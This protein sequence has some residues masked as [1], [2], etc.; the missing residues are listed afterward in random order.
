MWQGLLP[1]D[2]TAVGFFPLV[3]MQNTGYSHY[4][5]QLQSGRLESCAAIFR[6]FALSLCDT[7]ALW[8]CA[9]S[10]INVLACRRRLPSRVSLLVK[11][12]SGRYLSS[13]PAFRLNAKP[14]WAKGEGP[15]RC[16]LCPYLSLSTKRIRNTFFA[17]TCGDNG[18]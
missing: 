5:L 16:M 18:Q 2:N 12:V 14:T 1:W 7:Y 13:Q 15:H 9:L 4:G 3:T 17:L 11:A 10:G 6:N 8:T